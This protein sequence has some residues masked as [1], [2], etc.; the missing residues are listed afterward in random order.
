M[1]EI[2]I[3]IMRKNITPSADPEFGSLGLGS[4]VLGD[5]GNLDPTTGILTCHGG[6]SQ[7]QIFAQVLVS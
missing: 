7:L 5:L 1:M 6:G 3:R 2:K 4:W